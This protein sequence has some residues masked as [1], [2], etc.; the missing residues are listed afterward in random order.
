MQKSDAARQC[1]SEGWEFFIIE[2]NPNPHL[3]TDS[4]LPLAAQAAG[5][6]YPQLIERIL[7]S[8]LARER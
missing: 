3:A 7:E 5:L 4:E 1:A 8:A 2:V 6:A